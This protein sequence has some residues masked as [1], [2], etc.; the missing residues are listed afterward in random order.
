MSPDHLTVSKRT[1]NTLKTAHERGIKLAV[2]TGR[3]LAL[4]DNVLSQVPF[5]DYVIYSNARALMTETRKRQ[6]TAI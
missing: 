5:V 3:P 1:Y 2:A 4:I 6:S